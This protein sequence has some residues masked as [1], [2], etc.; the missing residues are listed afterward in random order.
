MPRAAHYG[1]LH[2]DQHPEAYGIWLTR[3]QE[4]PETI[5]PLQETDQSEIDDVLTARQLVKLLKDR[6]SDRD[7]D[8]LV[9]H[10]CY[11]AS[12]DE[13]A[14]LVGLTRSR[15]SQ[16]VKRAGRIAVSKLREE[17]P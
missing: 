1:K 10:H 11:G 2:R 14:G 4:P 9:A 15:V 16:I 3:N 6:M 7:F 13:I 8:F 5:V 12:Y 17:A